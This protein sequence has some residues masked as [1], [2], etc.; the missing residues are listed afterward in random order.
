MLWKT[1]SAMAWSA[2]EQLGLAS[3]MGEVQLIAD[4]FKVIDLRMVDGTF[5][6]G[7]SENDIKLP[8]G[9]WSGPLGVIVGME[10]EGSSLQL[11]LKRSDF[12]T[13][14]TIKRLGK[15]PSILQHK[16][17]GEALIPLSFGGVSVTEPSAADPTGHIV[18]GI[19]GGKTNLGGMSTTV[20]S[21]YYN[22]EVD[23]MIIGD[24]REA[25]RS[26]EAM[27]M[28]FRELREELGVG[29]FLKAQYLGL[30]YDCVSNFQ[31][32]LAMR[33]VLPFSTVELEQ[34]MYSEGSELVS[35]HLVPNTLEAVRKFIESN[36][37]TPHDVAKLVLHFMT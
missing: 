35:L 29:A 30:V 28:V 36:P 23:N 14:H 20:P 12:G 27:I 10:Q 7:L 31:P 21:G 9:M 34:K 13:Y 32:L 19:R 8:E 4:E 6:S 5:A 18:F 33:L 17:I 2:A 15:L 3:R 25:R 1:W 22:P 37:P 11:C 16:D 26:W 24:L